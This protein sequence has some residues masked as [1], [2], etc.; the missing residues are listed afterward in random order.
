MKTNTS[1][2]LQHHEPLPTQYFI[3][4]VSDKWWG[5]WKILPIS[6]RHLIFQRNTHLQ[7][8]Y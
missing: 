8:I 1:Y 2:I 3:R 6:F 4:V 7:L 5:S